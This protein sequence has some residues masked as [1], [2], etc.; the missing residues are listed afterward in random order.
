MSFDQ[1]ALQW[2]NERRIQRA[3]RIAEEMSNKFTQV[4]YENA[5]EFGCGTALVGFNL[6]DRFD[7]LL[8]MDS[9]AGMVE[10]A[11][12]KIIN[13]DASHV[14]AVQ[15]DLLNES[16]EERFQMIFSSMVFH[17]IADTDKILSKLYA[18]L[19]PQGEICIVDIDEED[20]HFHDDYPGFDGH[21]G[22]NHESLKA[23]FE[24]AGF[25]NIKVE[26]FYHDFKQ[27]K[28]KAIP[29]SLFILMASK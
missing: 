9:S 4:R 17:H 26:N 24:S 7:N 27:T 18:V 21:N 10:I 1:Y 23:K 15:M 25:K 22:F 16:I 6:M 29:Y 13:S 28:D 20:G 2:D 3:K 19:E 11:N 12:R 14:R 8:L 5:L